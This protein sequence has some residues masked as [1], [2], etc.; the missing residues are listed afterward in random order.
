MEGVGM[1]G[2]GE[3]IEED[4]ERI[5]AANPRLS[6]LGGKSIL[7]TG[8]AGFLGAYFLDV[9]DRLNGSLGRKAE[10]ICLDSFISGTPKRIAHLEG[11]VR[12]IKG[13]ITDPLPT[14][15]RPDYILHCAS[16]ASPIFYRQH[17]IETMDAN[18]SGTR[19]LLE[20]ARASRISGMVFFSTSEI[21][22]DPPPG[23]IPTPEGYRGNVSCTGP[24][25]CYD[26]SKRFGETL[27][28]NFN[29]VHKIPVK[30]V[31]PFNVYGPG[32]RIDDKRVI[33]DF[34]SD[35]FAGKGITLLSDGSATR[36]FCYVS[37][38]IDGF[39]KVMLDGKPGEAYN[40]GNDSEEIS[41]LELARKVSALFG[42]LEVEFQKSQ[43][44]DYLTD[45]PQ[46]RCPDLR[47]IREELGFRPAVALDE[48]LLR[49]K[50]WYEQV[51]G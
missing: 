11:K 6:E 4:V 12:L 5:I 40:V 29:R 36:S 43:D 30:T 28:V 31:R 15:V 17:P 9:F 32:L 34:F 1:S 24:R 18:V 47:K 25:A 20:F 38:A 13:S 35:G 26:E 48:G 39:L 10:I 8:G 42:G 16:I 50:G 3:I 2:P 45:N 49:M 27:C 37:D 23:S 19:N 33:P 22:G 14:G 44:R 7:V 46:R 41:M 51:R 21:Y